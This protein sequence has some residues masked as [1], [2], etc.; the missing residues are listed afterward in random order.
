[1]ET[2]S[3]LTKQA[4]VYALELN[5][6]KGLLDNRFNIYWAEVKDV[7]PPDLVKAAT[8]G[9]YR[10]VVRE[11]VVK[12][13]GGQGE[14]FKPVLMEVIRDHFEKQSKTAL[15]VNGISLLETPSQY[16]ISA[17]VWLE[18]E[19][20]WKGQVPGV[21]VPLTIDLPKQPE[22]YVERRIDEIIEQ[23]RDESAVL[24]PVET[25]GFQA[26]AENVVVLDCT[27]TLD[28]QPWEPGC[29]TN[30]KWD[31]VDRKRYLI[32]EMYD[33]ILGM[34]AGETKPLTVVLDER[35]GD[36]LKGKKIEQTFRVNQ[37]YR[38]DRPNIDDDLAKTKG[39]PDI[40]AYK[41][42]VKIQ[43]EKEIEKERAEL[44]GL[45]IMGKLFNNELVAVEPIPYAWLVEKAREIYGQA[46]QN[47]RT[48]EE[49]I[50][51]FGNVQLPD[52]SKLTTRQDV[53][54][55][56]GQMVAQQFTQ[57]LVLRAWGVKKG[58]EGDT[59]L[60]A[61][62]EYVGKVKEVLMETV[63]INEYVPSPEN[64]AVA[65]TM[66]ENTAVEPTKE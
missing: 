35:F 44:K 41:E 17:K 28:G 4:N 25:E 23:D 63:V 47:V 36:D 2:T 15:A 64:P 48:E 53:M 57:D 66:P 58:V 18:P 32:P 50:A 20:T 33:T 43:V 60:E 1:M 3:T 34:K 13:A 62:P 10:K 12:A 55:Y 46:R 42:A 7:L 21:D 61:L 22:G 6:P 26:T 59:T 39:F 29:F 19:V 30:K 9:G 37:I 14:F 11:R 56:I 49:L 65:P 45:S 31:L 54:A 5:V 8:K 38:R 52:G 16:A 40:N 51:S 24:T 27:S